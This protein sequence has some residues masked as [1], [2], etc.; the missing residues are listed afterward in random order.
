MRALA[1]AAA[2]RESTEYERVI[3]E[4]KHARRERKAEIERK[5]QR[6][7]AGYEKE[8]AILAANRNVAV[9]NATLKAIERAIEE[10]E[11]EIR[12]EIPEIPK[13]K[14]EVRTQDWVRSN[15]VT[16]HPP[17]ERSLGRAGETLRQPD[18]ITNALL[19]RMHKTASLGENENTKLQEFA[20]L[21]ADVESQVA[22]LPGLQCLNFPNAVQPIA[23]KL[24]SSLHG[25]WEK[26]IAKYSERNAGAYPGFAV[27]S[28][29][30]Q[31]QARM[32]NDPNI[33]IGAKLAPVGTPA[34]SRRVQNR[35]GLA[36]NTQPIS[37]NPRPSLR[38]VETTMKRCPF[39]DRAG[40]SLEECKAFAAKS[41][42]E[43]TEEYQAQP[44]ACP[45]DEQSN[46]SLVS[47]ELAD[48]LGAEG[49]LEKYYLSTCSSNKELKYGRIVTGTTIQALNGTALDLPTLIECDSIS[50]DKRE[51]PTP[52]M[53]RRFPHLKEIAGEIPPF[54]DDVDI[55]LLI[56]RDAPEL[57]KVRDFI[58]GPN[59][60]P[61]AQRLSLGW[62]ITGQMCLD[63]A[64]G[65]AHA[66]AHRTNLLPAN[67]IATLE[68]RP[69]QQ[70]T[71]IYELVPCPNSFKTMETL[72]QREEYLKENVF[73]TSGDNNEISLSCE[74][75]KFLE[76]ME[77]GVHKNESGILEMPLPFR[78]RNVKMPNNHVQAVNHLYGLLRTLKKKPQMERD[79]FA[80]MEKILSKGPSFLRSQ[81]NVLPKQEEEIPMDVHDPEVRKEVLAHNTNIGERR[82][83]GTERFSR[84]S[85]LASLQHAIANLIVMGKEFLHCKSKLQDL[86]TAS[87]NNRPRSPTV[88]EQ[89]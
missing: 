9:A 21:C 24:P 28:T 13:V 45:I 38:E 31:Y 80:F 67:Q 74:D 50:R 87:L 48:Q 1:E 40:H 25:K 7:H 55:H 77:S 29:V 5:H 54:D 83:L 23:E 26:E 70:E 62:T 81:T 12:C 75:R 43:K 3:A 46:P 73:Y 22:H 84:F 15:S 6:E 39:H 2:A 82:G 59:G 63:F 61:W 85:S 78:Q 72:S 42:E 18:V 68:C 20:D 4:K 79:Y 30:I 86:M 52:E 71:G 8:L 19:E 34:P 49:P 56:G 33:L 64:S 47:S 35:R 76:I 17:Q 53:V 32:K 16:Q 88:L 65:P 69:N 51:V 27:F 58:N 60:A 44:N 37:M 66:L 14:S 10:E 89:Q 36:T 41:L 11:I 57:L